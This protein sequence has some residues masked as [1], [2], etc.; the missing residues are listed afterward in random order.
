MPRETSGGIELALFAPYND[1]VLL[2]G[3][4]DSFEPAPMTRGKDGWWRASLKLPDGDYVYQFRVKSKSWFAEG[5][6]VDVPDPRAVELTEYPFENACLR[7]RKGQRVMTEYK[8]KHDDKPLPPN[9]RLVIYELHVGDF[10][11]GPGDEPQRGQRK[12]HFRDAIEKLDYLAELGINCIEFMPVNEFPFER[13]WGYQPY[14]L[15]AVENTYGGP[16]DFCALVDECHA[17]GIRVFMDAVF[18]H[19]HPESPLAQIDH[20][21]WF[22]QEAPHPPDQRYGPDFNY[23]H[24]DDTLKIHPARQYVRDAV[25]HWLETF[26]IDGIRFDA[27]YLINNYDVLRDLQDEINRS[28]KQIKPFLTIAENLPQNPAVC[29]PDGPLDAAWHENLYYQ[30]NPTILGIERYGRHP[31]NLDALIGV[32]DLRLDGFASAECVVNYIDNHDKDRILWELGAV[33]NT[34]DAAAFRRMKL[35]AS[36]LMTIPGIPMIWMGQEFGEAAPKTLDWQRLDWSLLENE[37]NR[38][39]LNHYRMLIDLRKTTPA[40]QGSAFEVIGRDDGRA[41]LAFKRWNDQGNLVVVVANLKDQYAGE[42][43]FGWPDNGT[44]HERVWNYD[45]E[46]HNNSLTDTLGESEVKI[47]VK[48]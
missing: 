26:H 5:Q 10:T 29:G 42:F 35:G 32:I 8:W 3:S 17:R 44:W 24:W 22:H 33:A 48:K 15:F 12:G 4:W 46:V 19:M 28:V 13:S 43:T 9:E 21:Y 45:V 2:R 11:G 7:V 38:S 27:T 30:L 18:N 34:F 40:L 1:E 6:H 25:I 16:D 36:L 31:Y 41:I 20:N 47:Y 39:L 23:E 14:S 37:T